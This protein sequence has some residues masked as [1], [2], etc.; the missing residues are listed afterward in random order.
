MQTQERF[1]EFRPNIDSP[2]ETPN[3]QGYVVP[4][5]DENLEENESD[6]EDRFDDHTRLRTVRDKV[7]DVL[8]SQSSALRLAA[9]RRLRRYQIIR[10]GVVVLMLVGLLGVSYSSGMS[11]GFDSIITRITPVVMACAIMFYIVE[12]FLRDYE[13]SLESE[14]EAG[15]I[16]NFVNGFLLDWEIND[17]DAYDEA[18]RSLLRDL[19]SFRPDIETILQAEQVP[20]IVAVS[21]LL[22]EHGM[23]GRAPSSEK[24]TRS[25]KP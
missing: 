16:E 13:V 12:A 8:K 6:S 9:S 14:R 10:L 19:K 5:P 20:R 18:A 22:R 3:H 7:I 25:R 24:A 17:A 11:I 15:R 1:T 4:L 2:S 23:S 21:S